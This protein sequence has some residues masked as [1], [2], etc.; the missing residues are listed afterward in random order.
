VD[1][2]DPRRWT[3]LGAGRSLAV[4]RVRLALILCAAAAVAIGI[5]GCEAPRSPPVEP[6][7]VAVQPA[8]PLRDAARDASRALRIAGGVTLDPHA[9]PDGGAGAL[10]RSLADARSAL[11]R[12]RGLRGARGRQ[13]RARRAIVDQLDALVDD[14]AAAQRL[15]SAGAVR[16]LRTIGLRLQPQIQRMER[17]RSRL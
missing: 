12:L 16:R 11:L 17:Q 1:G 5:G 9:Y 6:A 13:E 4:V 14:L 3:R 7:A 8:A 2:A 15:A 10:A